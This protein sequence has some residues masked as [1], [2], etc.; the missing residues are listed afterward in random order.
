MASGQ[1]NAQSVRVCRWCCGQA[2]ATS[3]KEVEALLHQVETGTQKPRPKFLFEVGES[4]RIKEGPFADFHGT[5]EEVNYDKN[6]LRVVGD[7]FW[8]I[9]AS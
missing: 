3:R 5:V 9:D 1:R 2:T 8:S 6:K 4:V 7:Y